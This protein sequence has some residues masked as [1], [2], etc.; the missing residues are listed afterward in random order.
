MHC[1]MPTTPRGLG[2]DNAFALAHAARALV[3]LNKE[4]DRGVAMIEQALN[5]NSNLSTVW[6]MRGWINIMSSKPTRRS[7]VHKFFRISPVDPKA[8]ACGMAWGYFPLGQYDDSYN[9][10]TRCLPCA[11]S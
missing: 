3:F 10:A 5:L 6:I 11:T 1:F 8:A 9:W 2:N 7:K 4:Y